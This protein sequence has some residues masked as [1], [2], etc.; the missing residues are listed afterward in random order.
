MKLLLLFLSISICAICNAATYYISPTGND[1]TGT[2]TAANP[3]KTLYKATATVSGAGDIIHVNAGTYIETQ[4][5]F[6]KV[7]VSIEGDGN[8]SI[9]KSTLSAN[10]VEII[11]ARSNT[12][13]TNGNQHI[14]NLQFDG[15]FTTSW[16]ITVFAR[17]NVAIYNCTFINFDD[18]GVLF[19][20]R[21]GFDGNEPTIYST[22]NSFY[23]NAVHNC[24]KYTNYGR[25]GLWAIGQQGML[26]HDNVMTQTQ[27]PL[28]QNGWLIKCTN[29]TKGVKIYNNTLTKIPFHGTYGGDGGWDFAI[30]MA[31]EQGV[32]IYN[33][34]IQGAIDLNRQTKGSYAY[35][36]W[37]H[38]NIINQPVLND[39][40]ESGI[41]LEYGTETAIIENN[42]LNNVS[43]GVLINTRAG[44]AVTNITI[45]N[46]LLTNIGRAGIDGNNGAFIII[47]SEGLPLNNYFIDG[48]NVYNNTMIAS[49]GN[50]PNYGV[51]LGNLAIGFENNI[52]IKNNIIMN[53]K[54]YWITSN[55]IL[56]INFLDIQ[57]NNLQNN[58]NNNSTIFA[59]AL[60]LSYTN[61]NNIN[62]VPQFASATNYQLQSSSP[63]IDAGVNVGLPFS[64]AAPDHGYME[65]GSVINIPPTANAG[66]DQNITLPTNTVSLTG[67]G[68]DPD[69]TITTYLWTKV[70]GPAT[71]TITTA[72]NAATT[73][74]ALV[75]G[76]YQFELKVTDNNGATGR[77]TMQVIVN[78]AAAVNIPP[79]A[80]AGADQ[81]ITLPTNTVS[82]TGTGNDPDGTITTYLWTKVAGPATGTITTANNAATT[83]TRLIAGIYKFELKV[84]DNNGATGRDTMQVIVF[85]PNIAP[86]ANAGLNQSITLPTNTANLSGSGTDVDGTVVIYKWT[87]VAGPATGTITNSNI[88]VTNVT[89]LTAGIYLFELRITDNNGATGK[90]TMQVIVN[91]EN[92]PPVAN[93]GADQSIALPANRITLTGSGTDADGTIAAY[94][95][96]QISGPV[97]K[98]TS[99]NTAITVLD[100][101]IAGNYKFELMVTDNRGATGKDTVSVIVDA[102]VTTSQSTIKIYP[103]PVIDFT[104]LEINSTAVNATLLVIITDIQGKN[105]Y[106]KQLVTR[107]Y[108]TR[109]KVNM[110]NLAKGTYYITV[111]FNSLEKQTI[112]AMKQ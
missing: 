70:A 47:S 12:E 2:G 112:K 24:A 11:N 21:V 104:T 38:D 1:I 10:Q 101:L 111:Y 44:D 91:P 65:F 7:G 35:S 27:R 39:K 3:W 88:P 15:Q 34:T 63:C 5:S 60:P 109:E 66:A 25:G 94:T 18:S 85:A 9:I 77:D 19:G 64:G 59:G 40:Y 37:I 50:R 73:V 74:T 56:P 57:Y 107:T 33:N 46:N 106:K 31:D 14:S 32:E 81:N 79:T 90:D 4:Q 95:W 22:G 75:Q 72:N 30:E 102:A 96:K 29:F 28:G 13:G 83:V 68:N 26:I 49:P 100:N 6:L 78:P 61:L 52:N 16:A 92:I 8:T 62:V 98:L 17:S 110:N 51:E 55:S 97:D 23:N 80:I 103:N 58:G 93:A 105:V 76:T 86:L 41:I 36:A 69:G 99:T 48:F 71:G 84:T 43:G 82:L 67:T 42:V 54:D 45:R 108:I 20:G 89:G 53:V 87:K